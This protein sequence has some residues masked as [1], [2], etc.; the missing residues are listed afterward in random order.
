MKVGI[1][2]CGGCNP[3]FNRSEWVKK[4]MAEYIDISFEPAS[5][6]DYYDIILII[7]GCPNSCASHDEL[8]GKEKIFVKSEQDI[9]R[10]RKTINGLIE[11]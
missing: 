10:V 1:K 6:H 7:N 11:R 3:Q 9:N 4:L 8:K 2:Y 5:K